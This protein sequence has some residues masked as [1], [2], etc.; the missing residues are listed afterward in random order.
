MNPHDKQKKKLTVDDT[1]A[2]ID[3]ENLTVDQI[4]W[5]C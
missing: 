1:V 2:S 3:I 4:V 5:E